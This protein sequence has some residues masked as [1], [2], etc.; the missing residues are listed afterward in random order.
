MPKRLTLAIALLTGMALA[1]C[2]M[3]A[4]TTTSP[5]SGSVVGTVT[6][7]G[8]GA[9]LELTNAT[10]SFGTLP[11]STRTQASSASGNPTPTFKNCGNF[12]ERISISGTDASGINTFWQLNNHLS[13]NPCIDAAGATQINVYD[14]S[15][16]AP[17]VGHVQIT[18]T[19]TPISTY[20]AGV[21]TP[22]ALQL[23]MPCVGSSGDTQIATFSVNLTAVVA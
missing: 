21:T 22:L 3:P 1:I 16:D 20:G 18:K 10:V 13:S 19:A 11:F 9:C 14:L 23:T 6:A 7:V 2:A 4:F 17:P 5:D 8:G 15:F 12:N